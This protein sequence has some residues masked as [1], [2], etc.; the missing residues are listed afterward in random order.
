MSFQG[1]K[2]IGIVG[3]GS[4][5]LM[6]C[7]EAAK[8]GISTCLLDP[9]VNCVGSQLATEHIIGAINSENI[10]KLSLRCDK[11]IF[12]DKSDFELVAKLH[13]EIFPHKETLNELCYFKNVLDLVELLEIPTAKIFYQDNNQDAFKEVDGLTMP[14]RFIKQYKGYSKQMDIYDQED[15]TEFIMEVDEDA[16][17]FIL[18]PIS[19]YKQIIACLCL[20]DESGKIHLYHPIEESRDEEHVC[21]IKT[22]DSLTKTM[23]NR[24][25]RYNR[26][27]VKELGLVGVVTIKYGIKAN[28]SVELME[29]SPQLGL[30]S[31]LTLE[32]YEHSVFEQYMRLVLG[33]KVMTPEL[34]AHAHGTIKDVSEEVDHADEGH[35]YHCGQ[36]NLCVRRIGIVQES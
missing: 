17:S 19:D 21:H 5:S 14:F 33:M 2:Q 1:I 15:L 26:K 13:A 35:F 16:E 11:I 25:A 27:I 9:Q 24:L 12:N 6:L 20:V 23:I 29:V 18:Q 28:K 32:A 36:A 4:S 30:V 3:G 34:I 31:L 8:L 22:A 7:I 10:K